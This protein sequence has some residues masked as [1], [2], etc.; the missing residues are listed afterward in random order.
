MHPLLVKLEQ[1]SDLLVGSLKGGDVLSHEGHYI[2]NLWTWFI[3]T[4]EF[5]FH[6][7][8]WELLVMVKVIQLA[9]QLLLQLQDLILDE[10]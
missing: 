1:S 3:L 7:L 5:I 2:C 4:L 8:H 10:L 6:H 9:C